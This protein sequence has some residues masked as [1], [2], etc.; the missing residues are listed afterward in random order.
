MKV[1]VEELSPIKKK[2]F[3]EVSHEEFLGKLDEAYQRLGKKVSIKGFRKGKVPRSV[4]ERFYKDQT[5]SD[6]LSRVIQDSYVWAL[7]DQKINPVAPPKILD[8]KK[9]D[10]Q[11]VSYQA[12]VEVRPVVTLKTYKGISL[13]KPS[14]EVSEEELSRELEGLRNA[15]AQITPVAEGTAVQSGQIAIVDFVGKL[16]DQPFEGG[17]GKGMMIEVGAGRFLKDFE[18]GILGMKKGE[19]KDVPVEFPKDYPSPELAGKKAH[20]EISLNDLKEK[21]LPELND[22]FAKDLG[23]FESL[24]Q[25]KQKIKENMVQHKEHAAR[26]ELYNQVVDFLTQEHPVEVPG[27]MIEQELDAM[28][29]NAKRQLQQQRLTFEQAGITPEGFRSQNREAAIRRIKAL[30]IFEAVALAEKVEVKPEELGARVQS[31]AASLGQKPEA[32]EQ[33]YRQHNM[34]PMLIT[35]I[36]EEKVLDFLL[37]EAKISAKK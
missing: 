26:G 33:Y 35:Q 13:K 16:G 20:F 1:K 5:E 11:P 21:I 10:S 3:I 28:L 2:L 17:S 29:E 9:E 27:G 6:V 30:L 18:E 32:V 25:V 12:E 8:L 34:F 14:V 36:L 22:D 31:I 37:A 24:E 15:H 23:S 19:S 4:L 7:E